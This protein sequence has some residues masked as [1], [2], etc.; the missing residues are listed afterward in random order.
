MGAA[1]QPGQIV[2]RAH[3]LST[4]GL[5][6]GPDGGHGEGV[7]HERV[8]RGRRAHEPAAQE[9]LTEAGIDAIMGPYDK[10]D[11][12]FL[13]AVEARE[14]SACGDG[15]AAAGHSF[16]AERHRLEL[17]RR[18]REAL[19]QAE[20]LKA[21]RNAASEEV[22]RRKKAGQPA[23]DLLREL[24]KS[25]ELSKQLEA[26]A[27][28][29]DEVEAVIVPREG[30]NP[31]GD[32]QR[33]SM[34]QDILKGRRTEIDAM[35]G[36]IAAKGFLL[37]EDDRALQPAENVVPVIREDVLDDLDEGLRGVI[38]QVSQTL[39]TD[40]HGRYRLSVP[41]GSHE[42]AAAI[43]FLASEDASY[44]NGAVLPVDGGMTA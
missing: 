12:R 40:E 35:N 20:T 8:V 30:A 25:S 34:A 15:A 29:L 38:D 14:H 28:A 2:N 6:D 23:D 7:V 5:H 24:K 43:G 4:K 37:L 19:V 42:I 27:K 17:D 44:V 11:R 3:H 32:I 36:F 31:R 1:S 10:A 22:A 16:D 9:G 26:D 41:A 21:S 13:D 39:T 18:R 33:P